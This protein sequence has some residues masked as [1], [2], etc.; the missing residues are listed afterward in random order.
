MHHRENGEEKTG[1]LLFCVDVLAFA[2][3]AMMAFG[4]AVRLHLSSVQ[5]LAVSAAMSVA[6]SFLRFS[7]L[8][9]DLLN[10]IQ[11]PPRS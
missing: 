1:L 5:M 11:D 4:L 2:G 6:G 10:L 7:D 3:L 8:G 9:S